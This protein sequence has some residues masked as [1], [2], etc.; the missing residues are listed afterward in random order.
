[1]KLLLL[2]LRVVGPRTIQLARERLSGYYIL[3]T[4]HN[5]RKTQEYGYTAAREADADEQFLFELRHA[6]WQYDC[7]LMNAFDPSI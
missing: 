1:M 2:K 6:K 5:D 3:R 7:E 4:F